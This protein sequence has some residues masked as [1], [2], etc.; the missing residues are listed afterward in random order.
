MNSVL[1]VTVIRG[2]RVSRCCHE[3]VTTVSKIYMVCHVFVTKVL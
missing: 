1:K 3:Y 2:A